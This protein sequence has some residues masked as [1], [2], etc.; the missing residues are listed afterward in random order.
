M[1]YGNLTLGTWSSKFGGRTWKPTG[2]AVF[3]SRNVPTER[4]PPPTRCRPVKN[5]G[6]ELKGHFGPSA[7]F[8][9]QA[10]PR[11]EPLSAEA[12]T[13]R[14]PRSMYDPCID[15]GCGQE[16]ARNIDLF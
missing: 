11:V 4:D 13:V 8:V 16:S 1:R 14:P 12:F 10:D 6:W 2:G 7:I 5:D 3:Q 9:R 15:T